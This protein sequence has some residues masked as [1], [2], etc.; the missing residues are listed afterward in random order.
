MSDPISLLLAK[1]ERHT[2]L[3]RPPRWGMD[4]DCPPADVLEWLADF[5]PL[6]GTLP[7]ARAGPR[8]TWV[9]VRTRLERQDVGRL[10]RAARGWRAAAGGLALA[11]AAL[12]GL[13]IL[14]PRRVTVMA[15]APA[16]PA[17]PPQVAAIE[18]APLYATMQRTAGAQSALF[19]LVTAPGSAAI[20][21]TPARATL[22]SG[23][24]Y[25][26][27]LSNARGHFLLGTISPSISHSL[28]IAQP[29]RT[30]LM[31]GSQ[32]SVTL[33]PDDADN[34]MKKEHVVAQ[35]QLRKV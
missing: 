21:S 24:I 5:E 29:A 19:V 3:V 2:G 27:W 1:I 11:A 20:R 34:A 6:Y 18:P 15:P 23:H 32:L 28:P 12:A 4:P 35:G 31:L 33:D 10:R 17:A 8:D 9:A 13:W 22:R 30:Q 16:A 7:L 26:L 25:R 14:S